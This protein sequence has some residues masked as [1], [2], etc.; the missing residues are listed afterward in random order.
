M[1]TD[2]RLSTWHRRGGGSLSRPLWRWVFRGSLPP[3]LALGVP[4]PSPRGRGNTPPAQ[5]PYVF[6][7]IATTSQLIPNS[8]SHERPQ[9]HPP[10]SPILQRPSPLFPNRLHPKSPPLLQQRS[11]SRTR[12]AMPANRRRARKFSPPRLVHNAR[13]R[14]RASRRDTRPLESLRIRKSLEK[15]HPRKFPPSQPP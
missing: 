14:P 15:L 13:S 12:S 5:S 8:P 9:T 11:V 4:V 10:T 3:A 1:I 7:T 6:A 2:C